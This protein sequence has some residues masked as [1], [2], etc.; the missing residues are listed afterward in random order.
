MAT[1]PEGRVPLTDDDM[2]ILLHNIAAQFGTR[3]KRMEDDLRQTADRFSD[4]AK[5]AANRRHWTGHE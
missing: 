1:L 3:D 2:V 5:R 4:L